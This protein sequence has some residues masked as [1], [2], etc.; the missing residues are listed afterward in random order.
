MTAGPAAA[1]RVEE[2]T[3][4]A[5]DGTALHTRRWR[6]SDPWAA[7]L[8][9]HGLAEHSGRYLHVGEALAA[10]GI[11]V[12]AYDQRG[13]GRS[14]GPRAFVER[15]SVLHDD[16]RSRLEAVRASQPGLPLVLYGHSMGGLVAAGYVLGETARPLPDLLVLSAPG[17]RAAIPRW[18]VTMATLLSGLAPRYAVP[19]GLPGGG[20][21]RDDGVQ[22]RYANDPLLVPRSTMRFAAE[23]FR[24]QD[25]IGTLLAA[26]R[27]LPVPTYVFHGSDDP[28]VPAASSEAL[29]GHG[30]VTRHVHDE[31]RHECHNEPEWRAVLGEVVVWIREQAAARD[32]ARE[33]AARRALDSG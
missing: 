31:L 14:G 13:F 2:G 25:R 3:A 10:D 33:P 28:I 30:P 29:M 26:G 22:V 17:L 19:N 7:L 5:P 27:P 18:R 12:H 23:A 15:W 6:A 32:A 4:R 21:S 16:L 9:V 8:L 20:L 11:E 1:E 24:E